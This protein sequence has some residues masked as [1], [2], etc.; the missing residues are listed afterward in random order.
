LTFGRFPEFWITLA[1]LLPVTPRLRGAP[2]I[3]LTILMSYLKRELVV[4]L[5]SSWNCFPST[6][7]RK[8]KKG[9]IQLGRRIGG[10]K[11]ATAETIHHGR[12]VAE[13]FSAAS[14]DLTR[15]SQG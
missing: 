10:A 14:A 12:K 13:T 15:R 5:L 8:I 4:G 3:M 2:D 6:R 11:S 9:P 7:S 1:T